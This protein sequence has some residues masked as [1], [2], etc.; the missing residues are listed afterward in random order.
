MKK[1]D[2]LYGSSL[3]LVHGVNKVT[4]SLL[5]GKNIFEGSGINL[6]KI[7]ATDAV[8][9]CSKAKNLPIG[10]FGN[11][12]KHSFIR[13]VRIFFKTKL[14]VR[15]SPLVYLRYT[16]TVLIP[17]NRVADRYLATIEDPADIILFQ[18]FNTAY[19]YLNKRKYKSVKTVIIS[20]ST[21]DLFHQLG[22]SYPELVGGI[23]E[24]II[25][26]RQLYVFENIDQIIFVSKQ[27]VEF[28]KKKYSNKVE[29]VY[30]GLE[31]IEVQ[32]TV[33]ERDKDEPLK[34]VCV[35]SINERKGQDILIES[36]KLLDEGSR[37]K[38]KFYIVGE[39]DLKS[40][41]IKRIN[42]YGL[43]DNFE[44]LGLRNDVSSLLKEMD[45]Y[46]LP[47]R[48]EGLPIAIIEALREGLYIIASNVGGIPELLSSDYSE[49]IKPD[50]QDLKEALQNVI[51]GKIDFSL[52]KKKA[53][54]VFL[55]NFSLES[56]INKYC[57]ILGKL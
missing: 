29:F 54:E 47:S 27:P 49:L 37:K 10:E 40:D 4:D 21:E 38:I 43:N 28:F 3:K 11:A 20:H 41:L 23:Y 5:K 19:T 26:K 48:N 31:D 22:L 46:V 44:F 45:C 15:F 39:G 33:R 53:R 7:Y 42:D 16:I 9:D 6:R 13:K 18:D 50:P 32:N 36:V 35:G 55:K 30:N 2:I 1:L 34:L 57:T 56:M 51:S 12:R 14:L 24:E 17:A 25:R 52:N 8:V